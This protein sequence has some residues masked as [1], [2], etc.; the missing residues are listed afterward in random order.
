[1]DQ[2][3]VPCERCQH[4]H[5]LIEGPKFNYDGAMVISST[6]EYKCPQCGHRFSIMLDFKIRLRTLKFPNAS[7]ENRVSPPQQAHPFT[8]QGIARGFGGLFYARITYTI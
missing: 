8:P 4:P 7:A 5:T 6:Y 3:D 2:T 1:M